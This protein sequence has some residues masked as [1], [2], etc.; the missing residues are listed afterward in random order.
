M[1]AALHFN[2]QEAPPSLFARV[3]I[4]NEYEGRLLWGKVCGSIWVNETVAAC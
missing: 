1:A 4:W 2:T 3:F